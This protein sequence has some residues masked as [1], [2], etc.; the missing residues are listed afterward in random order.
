MLDAGLFGRKMPTYPTT[1]PCDD[2]LVGWR[3][4]HV[5][6]KRLCG[7]RP[8]CYLTNTRRSSNEVEALVVSYLEFEAAQFPGLTIG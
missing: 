5:E 8:V 4:V 1:D 6:F 7:N 2:P 3:V